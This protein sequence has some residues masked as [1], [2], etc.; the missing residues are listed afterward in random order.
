[1]KRPTVILSGL[2]L[3]LLLVSLVAYGL[4][5][6]NTQA[7]SSHLGLLLSHPVETYIEEGEMV[8]F[9]ERG[10]KKEQLFL[11]YAY[12]RK[13]HTVTH[14]TKPKLIQHKQSKLI[15]LSA[16]KAEALHVGS[17][18]KIKKIVFSDDV[19]ITNAPFLLSTSTLTYHPDV[20]LA[21][22][23]E[24]IDI[25]S[26]NLHIQ[27][28]GMNIHMGSGKMELLNQVTSKYE[29]NAI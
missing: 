25:S 21:K 22:T 5:Y 19:R 10:L 2:S 13:E 12:H 18:G 24:L 28:K 16:K 9:D 3:C 8:R 11:Q 1:M 6:S 27:A 29:Y 20:G 7:T 26:E 4:F 14:I 17:N 15:E 23:D